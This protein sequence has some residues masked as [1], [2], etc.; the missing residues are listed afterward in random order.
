MEELNN[1]LD[2]LAVCDA[3]KT[4]KRQTL[5]LDKSRQ[6]NSAEHSWHSALTALV[7]FEY[8][9]LDDVDL[10]HVVKMII[11]HDLVEVYAGD[12]PAMD[13]SAQIDN[14]E[15]AMN[16]DN[17]LDEAETYED[18][19][20]WLDNIEAGKHEYL[21]PSSTYFAMIDGKIVG[22]VDIRHKLNDFLLKAGGHIGYSVHPSE[23]RKGY[24]T[25]ILRLALEK[26]RQ[27]GIEKVL[28][29][30][31]KDNVGSQKTILYNCGVLENELQDESGNATLRYWIE[32]TV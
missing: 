29:T 15:L 19:L 28:V 16:G 17:G 24:A 26:C 3:L 9:V 23:R 4:V 31:D 22:I 30:C 10:E 2:F 20:I 8:C 32:V 14:K 13:K 11:V 18:W 6:E 12:S 5:L 7:L 21:L 1:Q 27:R 25:E